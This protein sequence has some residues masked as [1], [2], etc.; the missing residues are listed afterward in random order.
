MFGTSCTV[1]WKQFL[2]DFYAMKLSILIWNPGEVLASQ[3]SMA[4]HVFFS[5][6][7]D[8]IPNLKFKV[9]CSSHA[10]IQS[11]PS[12]W[13]QTILKVLPPFTQSKVV[14]VYNHHITLF[15]KYRCPSV[16]QNIQPVPST[17]MPT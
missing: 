11:D 3:Y 2:S 5:L 13:L 6:N 14:L 15:F 9:W 10:T 4:K 17:M 7:C 12:L 8:Q 1:F 16:P